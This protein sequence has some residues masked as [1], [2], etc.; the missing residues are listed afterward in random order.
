VPFRAGGETAEKTHRHML[1]SILREIE[2]RPQRVVHAIQAFP[3]THFVVV[4]VVA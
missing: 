4:H 1:G 3:F 2:P